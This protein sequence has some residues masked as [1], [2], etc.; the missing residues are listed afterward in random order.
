[1]HQKTNRPSP[2]PSPSPFPHSLILSPRLAGWS[3]FSLQ[4]AVEGCCFLGFTATTACSHA[5]EYRDVVPER[6][7]NSAAHELGRGVQFPA[8]YAMVSSLVT[9][10]PS[11]NV[12]QFDIILSD[13]M[14]VSSVPPDIDMKLGI[15][16]GNDM[17]CVL[18]S[19]KGPANAYQQQS[20][21]QRSGGRPIM[22]PVCLVIFCYRP[23][24]LSTET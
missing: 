14:T 3:C 2:S 7:N 9:R 16:H 22:K 15:S 8:D 18:E 10:Q 11:M 4:F 6:T 12:Y 17:R 20:N 13:G 19:N 1:M 24:I 21:S 5:L 23:I